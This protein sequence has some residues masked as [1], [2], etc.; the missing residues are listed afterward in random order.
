MDFLSN[1]NAL[2]SIYNIVFFFCICSL[3]TY[4]ITE[5]AKPLLKIKIKDLSLKTFYI[6]LIACISGAIAGYTLVNSSL[7]F[8]VG[9][10]S[11]AVNNF[12]VAIMKQKVEDYVDSDDDDKSKN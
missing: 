1:P 11:G 8:W 7:G 3:I 5:I 2:S 12:V 4:G 6:R 9:F 10:S